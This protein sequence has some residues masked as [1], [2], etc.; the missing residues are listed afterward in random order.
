M[1][2]TFYDLINSLRVEEAKTKLKSAAF[3]KYSITGI[4]ELC[5]F[6]SKSSFYRIFKKETG[7]TPTQFKNNTNK[8]S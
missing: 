2:T 6:N 8:I 4:A 1:H 3:D 5:G 7:L